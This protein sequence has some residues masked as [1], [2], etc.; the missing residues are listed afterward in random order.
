MGLFVTIE[1]THAIVQGVRAVRRVST[2]GARQFDKWKRSSVLSKEQG[3]L[4]VKAKI[5]ISSSY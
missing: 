4:A 3:K 5:E 1:D 2:H